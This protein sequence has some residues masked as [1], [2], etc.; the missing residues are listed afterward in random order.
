MCGLISVCFSMCFRMSSK[1][2]VTMCLSNWSWRYCHPVFVMCMVYD[3]SL[4]AMVSLSYYCIMDP[5][6]TIFLMNYYSGP[7]WNKSNIWKHNGS[8]HFCCHQLLF[9]CIRKQSLYKCKGTMFP[10]LPVSTLYGTNIGTW[11]DNDFRFVVTADHFLLKIIEFIFTMSIWSSSPWYWS[12]SCYRS[13][14]S[15]FLLLMQ[16]YLKW[17]T[18]LHSKH[19]FL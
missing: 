18:L 16:T 10:S 17:L 13:C 19:F 15:V 1:G 14:M 6:P 5:K 3:L 4:L 11:F 2:P 8:Y 12:A 9:C 7:Y